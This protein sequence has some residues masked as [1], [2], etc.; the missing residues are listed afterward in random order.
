MKKT[1]TILVLL[2]LANSAHAN[3][4]PGMPAFDVDCPGK[5]A[6]HA[7]PDGPVLIDSKEAESKIIDERHFE[8][9]GKGIKL[10]ITVNDDDSVTVSATGK[11]SNGQCQSVED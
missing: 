8:A 9:N 7:D 6:V 3:S 4:T 5:V 2:S 1:L 11:A 10:S